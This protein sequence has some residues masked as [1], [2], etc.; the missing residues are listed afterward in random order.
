MIFTLMRTP[1]LNGNGTRAR[2]TPATS[3][4]AMLNHACGMIGFSLKELRN[5]YLAQ[6]C[7]FKQA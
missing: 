6:A 5:T 4:E 3:V 1:K 2:G 7:S